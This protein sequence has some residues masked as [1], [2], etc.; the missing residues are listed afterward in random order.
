MNKKGYKNEEVYYIIS[1]QFWIYFCNKITK[2]S[3]E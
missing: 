1:Y 3:D 2:E